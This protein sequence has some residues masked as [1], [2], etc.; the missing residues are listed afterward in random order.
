LGPPD[1]GSKENKV[2]E[3]GQVRET[4]E[5][6]GKTYSMEKAIKGDVAI[7]RAWKVDEAGNCQFRYVWVIITHKRSCIDKIP[8]TPLEHS[9]QSWPKLQRLPL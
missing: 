8:D 3:K 6:D 2:L 4:R 9:V 7:L 5:F 1:E